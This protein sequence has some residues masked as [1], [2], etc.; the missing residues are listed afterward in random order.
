MTD[1]SDIGWVE[2]SETHP[3]SREGKSAD[4]LRGFAA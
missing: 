4:G 3:L 2:R 1:F